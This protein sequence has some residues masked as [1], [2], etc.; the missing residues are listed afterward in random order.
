MPCNY[1]IDGER[2][3]VITSGSGVLTAAEAL[4][5]Q[6]RLAADPAFHNDFS[7]LL[8]FTAL[9]DLD[10]SAD[11]I[12]HLAERSLYSSRSRRAF[13]VNSALAVGM[14]NMYA[15]YREFAGGEEEMKIF[16][17]RNEALRWLAG[18]EPE[19]LVK[20]ASTAG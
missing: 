18:A 17:D 9:T 3:L 7:Q 5:H 2:K 14:S 12:R 8:D 11:W 4:E 13:L 19:P 20:S 15:S 1:I 6:Q 16:R 10:I